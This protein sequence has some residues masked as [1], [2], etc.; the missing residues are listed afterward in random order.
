VRGGR[1]AKAKLQSGFGR[2]LLWSGLLK[3]IVPRFSI[4]ARL[5]N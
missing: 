1:S 3:Q 5:S 2:L 4:V